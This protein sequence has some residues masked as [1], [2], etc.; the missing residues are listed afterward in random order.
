MNRLLGSTMSNPFQSINQRIIDDLR[1]SRGEAPTEQLPKAA[2]A[3]R[4]ADDETA[5]EAYSN[6]GGPEDNAPFE[7]PDDSS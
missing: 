4:D 7:A 1:R 6:E 3:K 5:E 2:P